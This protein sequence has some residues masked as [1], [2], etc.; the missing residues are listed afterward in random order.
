[1]LYGG[2]GQ[3]GE[4]GAGTVVMLLVTAGA[5]SSETAALNAAHSQSITS[6]DGE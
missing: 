1:M 2:A 4:K 3:V 6:I 5:H